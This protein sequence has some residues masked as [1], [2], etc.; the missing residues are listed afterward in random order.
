[1]RCV[2]VLGRVRKRLAGDEVRG[3]F[4]LVFEALLGRLYLGVQR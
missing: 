1:M 2:R 3:G 4:E